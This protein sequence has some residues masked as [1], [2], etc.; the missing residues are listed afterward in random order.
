MLAAASR[1][2]SSLFR[3][4]AKT[5]GVQ[6]LAKAVPALQTFRKYPVIAFLFLRIALLRA[7][8]HKPYVYLALTLGIFGKIES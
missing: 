5:Q 4:G 1:T 3:V 2:A 6:D 8:S 7:V